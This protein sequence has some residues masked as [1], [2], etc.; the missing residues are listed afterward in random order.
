MNGERGITWTDG[1]THLLILEK[2]ACVYNNNNSDVSGQ[3]LPRR[4]EAKLDGN[5]RDGVHRLSLCQSV[6]ESRSH[7]RNDSL[8]TY[9]VRGNDASSAVGQRVI[10]QK[11][12]FSTD[13]SKPFSRRP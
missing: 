9:L 5:L 13:R 7:R 3:R 8:N 4:S 1:E 11:P 12:D 2:N 10:N 6:H